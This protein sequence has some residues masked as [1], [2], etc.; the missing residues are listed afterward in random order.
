MAERTPSDIARETLKQLAVRRM[1]PTPEHFRSIYD[2]IAGV[3]SPA[4][5]PEGPLRQILRVVPGQTPVQRRLLEQFEK[6]V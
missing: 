4:P 2:E 3:R 6:A 1:A 5:F